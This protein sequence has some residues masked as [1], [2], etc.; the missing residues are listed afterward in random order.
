MGRG[1]I[2][3]TSCCVSANRNT[4]MAR[5]F[6]HSPLRDRPTSSFLIGVEHHFSSRMVIGRMTIL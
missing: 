4:S 6:C 2:E 1:R 5:N 3:V